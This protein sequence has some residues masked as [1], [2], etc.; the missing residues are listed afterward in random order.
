MG[1]REPGRLA[2][3]AA[4]TVYSLWEL[5]YQQ[6][7]EYDL[8]GMMRRLKDLSAYALTHAE[9]LEQREGVEMLALGMFFGMTSNPRLREQNQSRLSLLSAETIDYQGQAEVVEEEIARR[10]KGNAG[11]ARE[12]EDQPRQ[13][14]LL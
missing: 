8:D 9:I 14:R 12:D 7:D 2:H 6:G 11:R 3:T 1:E 10:K 4:E 5:A 13:P